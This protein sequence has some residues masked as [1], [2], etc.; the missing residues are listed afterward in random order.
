MPM[1]EFTCTPHKAVAEPGIFCV[2]F[3][4][5]SWLVVPNVE[6][7]TEFF[8]FFMHNCKTVRLC[9]LPSQ[10]STDNNMYNIMILPTPPGGY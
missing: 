2:I 1:P 4:F 9:L 5:C 7:N 6:N 3:A 8:K 10:T